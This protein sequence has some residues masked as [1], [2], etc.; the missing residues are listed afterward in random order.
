MDWLLNDNSFLDRGSDWF[1]SIGA[2]LT[3]PRNLQVN[4][5]RHKR[6]T[7]VKPSCELIDFRIDTWKR[8]IQLQVIGELESIADYKI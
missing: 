4:L 2:K 6:K 3:L 7:I 1:R 5:K 8:A